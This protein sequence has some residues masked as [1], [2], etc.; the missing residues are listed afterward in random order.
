MELLLGFL[1]GMFLTNGI[2]HFVSGVKGKTH[3]TPFA[4]NSSAIVNVLWGFIN[5]IG[6]VWILGYSQKT[7]VDALSLDTFSMSFLAGVLV[8]SIAAAWL[9]SNKDARFPWFK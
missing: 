8:M 3:M 7:I 5:F 6:G 2:P 1:S 9:F 4:K